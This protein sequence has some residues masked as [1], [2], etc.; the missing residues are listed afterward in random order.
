M[1]WSEAGAAVRIVLDWNVDDV[2]IEARAPCARGDL[3]TSLEGRRWRGGCT[4]MPDHRSLLNRCFPTRGSGR[5]RPCEGGFARPFADTMTLTERSIMNTTGMMF[6]GVLIAGCGGSNGG[7]AV[8]PRSSLVEPQPAPAT[9]TAP[10]EAPAAAPV[11]PEVAAPAKPPTV[12]ATADVKAV[13]DDASMGKISFVREGSGPVVIYAELS[14]M[15][16][17]GTHAFYIHQ[18]GDCSGKGK[19]VGPHLDPT[20][21]KHGP[22]AS[23]QRHA[24]DLGNLTSDDASNATFSMTTDSL[25]IEG[26]RPDSVLNR[27]IVIHA[28]KDDKTGNGGP[29]LGCGVITLSI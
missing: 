12:T 16:K 27:S 24:G 7:N 26:D 19:K 17:N 3:L 10:A 5:Y 28:Q 2:E 13:K 4:A 6:V 23:S 21:A 22:P 20:K 18:N 9:V 15:K 8:A 14:G 29:A 1:R 11:V 25:T